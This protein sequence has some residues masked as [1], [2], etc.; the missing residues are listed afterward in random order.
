MPVEIEMRLVGL[1][2]GFD[3]RRRVFQKCR[4]DRVWTG[5]HRNADLEVL[6]DVVVRRLI[7]FGKP[8]LS[9]GW[10]HREQPHALA[11]Q[12]HLQIV[13][14]GQALDVLVAVS[15]QPNLDLVFAV[16]RKGIRDHRTAASADR[17]AVQ[18]LLLGEVRLKP[19]GFAA[20]RNAGT[21]DRYPADLLR[22]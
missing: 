8:S 22:R 16:Q 3:Q 17:K 1:T 13:R 6:V 20:W 14:L 2:C 7:I 19:D 9:L 21:S 12:Q 11:I 18:V 4:A 15:R 10:F 5:F